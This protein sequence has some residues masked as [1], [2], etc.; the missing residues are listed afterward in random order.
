MAKTNVR[1]VESACIGLVLVQTRRRHKSGVPRG[2]Y[3]H[4]VE[5]VGYACFSM[6]AYVLTLL[7]V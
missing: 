3:V 7:E 1:P 6:Y 5:K 2:W 4:G